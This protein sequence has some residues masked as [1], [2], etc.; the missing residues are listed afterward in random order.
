[1]LPSKE[2]FSSPQ[3]FDRLGGP[4]RW[5]RQQGFYIYRADRMIQSGGWCRLRT[6]DEH[7]K[8]ARASL[9]FQ[10]DLDSAFEINVAKIRVSLPPD[11]RDKLTKHIEALAKRARTAYDRKGSPSA[12][13]N[14]RG[15]TNHSPSASE[16]DRSRSGRSAQND[17]AGRL[18]LTPA[19]IREV[20]EKA[21]KLTGNSDALRGLMV[22]VR[23]TEP[24]VARAIG[25]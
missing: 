12:A 22:R 16:S 11:L 15:A 10:P 23:T 13:T 6:A 25:W 7:T 21:A 14:V 17:G 24:E 9:D 1:V 5:N 8:L 4:D 3:E 18:N 2:K 20:L 19:R